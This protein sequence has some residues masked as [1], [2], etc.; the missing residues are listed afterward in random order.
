MRRIIL[1]L[2]CGALLTTALYAERF[3]VNSPQA[4]EDC[5]LRQS[6]VTYHDENYWTGW[7]FGASQ[8]LDIGYAIAMWN[9]WRGN[10]LLRFD[11]GGVACGDVKDALVRI[12]KP[13]NVTQTSA[14]V[15]VGL[16]SVTE[17][18]AS[19]REGSMESMPQADAAS[20]QYMGSGIGWAGGESG[21]SV[22]GVDISAQPLATAKASKYEGQWLEFVI[23][24]ELVQ[25]WI[26]N[27]KSNAGLLLKVI[28]KSETLGDHVLFYSSEHSSG[29]GPEL[30][31]NGVR[32]KAKFEQDKSKPFNPRYVMPVE[33]RAFE[34]YLKTRDFRYVLWTTDPVVNMQG[35]QRIYPYYWD[36]VVYGEYVLPYAYYSFSQSILAIDDMIER[37]DSASLRKF[38]INRLRYLHIWE[39]N[40]EQRWYD[41]G[42]V[43]E[44][45]SPLQAAYIWLGSKKDNGLTFDGV[46]NKVHPKGLKNLTQ[47]Q[48]QLRRVAEVS[49][50]INNME[51]SQRQYDSVERFISKME[52]LRCIYF[53]KCNDAA[54]RVH[55]LLAEKND[56]NEMIDALGAFM[57][58]HDIY[59][60]Y[61]SYWQMQRWSYL[62][63]NTDM[64]ALNK[65]W[66]RQKFGEYSPERIE[67]RYKMCAS[68]WPDNRPPLQTINKNRL[69]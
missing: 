68:F 36:I 32:G 69:W 30:V 25:S 65:F 59:L 17:Q 64:V 27:P 41:C 62:M 24:A 13:K 9:Q 56:G 58:F 19:W 14:E 57:N 3:V 33:D 20:W 55:K 43:I 31:V 44:I 60:F 7:N 48:M 10:V 34:R 38:Q 1:M 50:C 5:I 8:T 22:E 63:D 61:D 6:D 66:K 2:L 51:M 37:G 54:Q 15:S 40:R 4:V 45:L 21:C 49:E 16:Y 42:D 18:N 53:N 67:K 35:K 47:Q 26:D 46:L 12:Y 23:P 29:K 52:N 11:M 39:Y 28:D